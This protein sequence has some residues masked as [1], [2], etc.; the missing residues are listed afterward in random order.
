M[1][2]VVGLLGE[3]WLGGWVSSNNSVCKEHGWSTKV[4][5]VGRVVGLLR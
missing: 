4:V 1:G 2:K 3:F 5:L